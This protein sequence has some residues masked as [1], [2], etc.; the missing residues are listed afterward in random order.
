MISAQSNWARVEDLVDLTTGARAV[1]HA[2]TERSCARSPFLKETVEV[3]MDIPNTQFLGMGALG[4]G[5][6]RD[7]FCLS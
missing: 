5:H 4:S 3:S 7:A 2:R 1:L 6:K